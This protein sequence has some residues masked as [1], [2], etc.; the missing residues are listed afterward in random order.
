M[1]SIFNRFKNFDIIESLKERFITFSKDYFE[2]PILKQE[3]LDNSIFNSKKLSLKEK[4]YDMQLK[5]CLIDELGFSNFKGNGIIPKYNY[6]QNE[7]K[8]CLRIKVP[9]NYNINCGKLNYRGEYTIIPINGEKIKDKIPK[10]TE[11]NLYTTRE[12]GKFEDNIYLKTE[13][14][15]IKNENIKPITQ[16][17]VAVFNF[18]IQTEEFNGGT[19]SLND[20]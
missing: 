19:T 12:F 11:E 2:R 14:F 17:G 15:N 20:L 4:T 6:L 13:K 3:L 10:K 9:G 1:L 8:I 5:C 18:S 7:D 16:N